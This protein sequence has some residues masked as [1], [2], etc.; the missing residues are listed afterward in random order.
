M[1][2]LQPRLYDRKVTLPIFGHEFDRFYVSQGSAAWTSQVP[3]APLSGND[4]LK[5]PAYRLHVLALMR[6]AVTNSLG[7]ATAAASLDDAGLARSSS[8]ADDRS[9]SY[10]PGTL[11]RMW[12]PRADAGRCEFCTGAFTLAA[13]GL[14]EWASRD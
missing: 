3:P 7:I 6:V 13:A 11:S 10:L 9:A 5:T 1:D 8:S 14:L 4:Q 2:N 12:R